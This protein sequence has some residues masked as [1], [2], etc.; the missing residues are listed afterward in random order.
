LLVH[1]PLQCV[2]ESYH[3]SSIFKSVDLRPLEAILADPTFHQ[4]GCLARAPSNFALE[5]C[6]GLSDSL[7]SFLLLFGCALLTQLIQFFLS[8]L[9]ILIELGS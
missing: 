6:S 1:P 8:L 5:Y 4:L 2:V 7:D 9:P 3:H